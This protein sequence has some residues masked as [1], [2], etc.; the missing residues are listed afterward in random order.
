M[1]GKLRIY[2]SKTGLK[3]NENVVRVQAKAKCEL[4]ED[5]DISFLAVRS[6]WVR[7][8]IILCLEQYDHQ[9]KHNCLRI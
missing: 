9:R 8:Y 5:Q 2:G 4:S 7:E 1:V 3:W 6:K